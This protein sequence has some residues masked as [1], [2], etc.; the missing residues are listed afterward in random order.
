MEEVIFLFIYVFL[1]AQELPMPI[2]MDVSVKTVFEELSMQTV[3]A[4]VPTIGLVLPM[5][6]ALFVTRNHCH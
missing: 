1:K 4:H 3:Y 6:P 5:E 2:A